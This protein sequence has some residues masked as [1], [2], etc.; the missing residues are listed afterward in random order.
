MHQPAHPRD[1]PSP[2][3]VADFVLVAALLGVLTGLAWGVI[4]VQNA[5]S[6]EAEAVRWLGAVPPIVAALCGCALLAVRRTYDGLPR[7]RRFL[8]R[9][10]TLG[11]AGALALAICVAWILLR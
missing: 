8:T 2:T 11:L 1:G 7:L 9:M 6:P 10:G 5:A 3:A 4:W